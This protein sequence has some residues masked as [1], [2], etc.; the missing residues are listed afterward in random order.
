MY[1]NS[2]SVV[3]P[4]SGLV[5]TNTFHAFVIGIKHRNLDVA[6]PSLQAQLG[7]GLTV[8]WD[9]KFLD[10]MKRALL[11][12]KIFALNYAL[13]NLIMLSSVD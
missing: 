12:C 3:R 9:D 13:I 6:K 7:I 1:S 2:A 10:E 5:V 4:P 11:A 8:S